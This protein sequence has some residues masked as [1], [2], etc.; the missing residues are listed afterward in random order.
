MTTGLRVLC[1]GDPHFKT[2]NVK[3]CREFCTAIYDLIDKQ[4]PDIIVVMGD[5]LDRH[6]NIH[7]V[8]LT[9]SINFILKIA[10]K[11]KTYLLIGNHDRPN[12]SDFLS[13]YHPFVGLIGN[14]NIVIVSEVITDSVGKYKFLFV[15]YV[16]P[17]RFKEAIKTKLDNISDI[18]CIFAHQE[19]YGTEMGAVI[20]T[21]GDKWNLNDTYIISGHIHNYCKPQK[22]ILYIGT[23]MQHNFGDDENKT[24]SMFTFNVPYVISGKIEYPIENRIDLGL[25]KKV[26]FS[27]KCNELITWIP[28][29]NCLIKLYIEGTS[30]EIKAL[31]KLDYLKKL[32]KSGIKVVYTI[33][34]ADTETIN[35]R[36]SDVS[37]NELGL[38]YINRLKKQI[39]NNPGQYYWFNKLFSTTSST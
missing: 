11:R 18:D 38:K 9:L 30:N 1:I 27:I 6:E 20:S 25:I 32:V 10:E 33:T 12:N 8:P 2:S 31:S 28:P 17:G 26:I 29:T 24:V 23:P 3:E 21:V 14:P 36:K 5:T 13:H 7:V 39:I 35:K 22:N 15:P 4:N 34:D 19:F 16:Y 37:N